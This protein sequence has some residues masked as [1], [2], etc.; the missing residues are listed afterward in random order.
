MQDMAD[1]GQESYRTG[2][3][4]D[5]TYAGHDRCRTENM[6]ERTDELEDE[7]RTG[8]IKNRIN[9]GQDRCRIRNTQ[10]YCRGIL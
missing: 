10:Y 7:S 9:A 6:Q 1:K 3:M 8:Q 4:E 5:R 2:Q